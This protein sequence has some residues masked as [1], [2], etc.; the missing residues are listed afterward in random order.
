[1]LFLWFSSVS[2]QVLCFK[3]NSKAILIFLL[4]SLAQISKQFLIDKEEWANKSSGVSVR[5]FSFDY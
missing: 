2:T 4:R 5:R 3:L 1:M